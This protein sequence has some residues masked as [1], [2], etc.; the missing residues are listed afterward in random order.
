MQRT[1]PAR[2]LVVPMPAEVAA[3]AG[4]T[5]GDYKKILPKE[6]F[7]RLERERYRIY[8]AVISE[9]WA[10]VSFSV[11]CLILVAVGCALG[12]MFKS[13]NFLSAF[14]VCAIPALL[15]IALIVT[16]QHTAENVP[17]PLPPN[18]NNSLKLGL[19]VIWS[20]NVIVATAAVILLTKLQRQ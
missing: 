7:R 8:N 12:M 11:S 4:R 13:G 6:D 17:S 2:S 10:R 18:W 1:F 3:L 20:G 9:I 19:T 16:G 5:V 14:A 15:C